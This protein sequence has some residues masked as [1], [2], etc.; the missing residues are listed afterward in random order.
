[1]NA[2]RMSVAA[3]VVVAA[4][5][6]LFVLNDIGSTFVPGSSSVGPVGPIKHPSHMD[7][8]TSGLIAGPHPLRTS[9]SVSSSPLLACSILQVLIA[10]TFGMVIGLTSSAPAHAQE[11][12][13]EF[14]RLLRAPSE[15]K[16]EIPYIENPEAVEESAKNMIRAAGET[17]MNNEMAVRQKEK[18]GIQRVIDE[19]K[20]GGLIIDKMPPTPAR[21]KEAE[22][23]QATTSAELQR[24]ADE[25]VEGLEQAQEQ[26]RRDRG[27]ATQI[28]S[29]AKANIEQQ[30]KVKVAWKDEVEK[31]A[32]ED[33]ADAED[34]ARKKEKDT[35][36]KV[37]EMKRLG[38]EEI[39]NM[40]FRDRIAAEDALRE[41]ARV[42]IENAKEERIL[43]EQAAKAAN[44]EAR[45]RA[46]SM[47]DKG[48]VMTNPFKRE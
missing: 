12:P 40:P 8:G 26:W 29:A 17:K 14:L 19:K 37:A 45:Q 27:S 7:S 34:A 30:R 21:V 32:S 3:R 18:D 31:Q 25:R 35:I 22:L 15:D 9:S 5:A 38:G 48:P 20:A 28:A 10:A 46:A 42:Y 36:M 2:Q 4:V 44:S 39:L 24:L 33:R 11:Q 16:K 47:M 23:L 43:A 6:A 41:D 13:M 1:M